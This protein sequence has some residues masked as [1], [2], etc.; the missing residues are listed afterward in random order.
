MAVQEPR[1]P[2]HFPASALD[3]LAYLFVPLSDSQVRCVLH[4]G[5]GS[6]RIGW[7]GRSA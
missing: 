4:F 6:T 7:R 3:Q 2:A 1:V 5:G